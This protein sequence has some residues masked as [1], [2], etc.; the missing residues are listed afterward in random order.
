MFFSTFDLQGQRFKIFPLL[1]G[2]SK[3]GNKNDIEKLD[4][5]IVTFI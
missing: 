1:E 5:Q 3:I 2:F 4:F